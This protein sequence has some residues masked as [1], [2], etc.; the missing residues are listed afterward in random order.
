MIDGHPT[1][2]AADLI[3]TNDLLSRLTTNTNFV[4]TNGHQVGHVSTVSVKK[5]VPRSNSPLENLNGGV[6]EKDY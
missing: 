4:M 1:L 2:V 6:K 3:V 5:H